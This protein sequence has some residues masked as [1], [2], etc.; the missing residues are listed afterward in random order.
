MALLSPCRIEA[1]SVS[2]L[3]G[4]ND[5]PSSTT[6][7]E[8][9]KHVQQASKRLRKTTSS[10]RRDSVAATGQGEAASLTEEELEAHKDRT[11]FHLRLSELVRRKSTEAASM[12]I[13]TLPM[14]TKSGKN[15]VSPS[16]YMAWLDFVSRDIE[17]FLFVR[18]NQESVLTFYS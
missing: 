10:A 3:E 1:E 12:V 2:V 7:K 8:W 13:M 5:A 11:Q 15:A 14:P 18:G 9:Q 16:L 17:S 4:V 6:E